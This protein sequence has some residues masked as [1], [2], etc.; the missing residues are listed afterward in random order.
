M[1]KLMIVAMLVVSVLW[2][3]YGFHFHPR[4]DGSDGFNRSMAAKVDDLRIPTWRD[5][6]RALRAPRHPVA[7]RFRSAGRCVR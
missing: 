7:S 5:G 6:I 2:A 4:A 1:P 3:A